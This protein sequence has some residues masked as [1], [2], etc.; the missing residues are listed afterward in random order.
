MYSEPH[1][2]CNNSMFGHL[3]SVLGGVRD[4]FV[5]PTS[6]ECTSSLSY[7]L[8]CLHAC[9]AVIRMCI[10]VSAFTSCPVAV[11]TR[12]ERVPSS[13]STIVPRQ[14]Q[15]SF[16]FA[17]GFTSPRL[18]SKHFVTRAFRCSLSQRSGFRGK[19]MGNRM[20]RQDRNSCNSFHLEDGEVSPATYQ[21]TLASTPYLR[22][23]DARME[24]LTRSSG[25]QVGSSTTSTGARNDQHRGPSV[26][27]EYDSDC[28]EIPAP[29]FYQQR[30]PRGPYGQSNGATRG[31]R[32]THDAFDF[33]NSAQPLP[34]NERERGDDFQVICP[35]AW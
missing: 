8:S 9:S 23:G 31:D 24:D 29:S 3:W 25:W 4:G 19:S 14:E 30:A 22:G 34:W 7:R 28:Y 5:Y 13:W 18:T 35:Q 11:P 21:P 26:D 33:N 12:C 15:H 10:L 32:A 27:N 16:P 20:S 1:S 2:V 6:L 17:I